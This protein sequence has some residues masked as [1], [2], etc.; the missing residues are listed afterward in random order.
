[1]CAQGAGSVD[2][3]DDGLQGELLTVRCCQLREV[4]RLLSQ[5]R[6][7]RT[8]TA[9]LATVAGST[10][11]QIERLAGLLPRVDRNDAEEQ[12]EQGMP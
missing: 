6:G 10:V 5:R 4:R 3:I 11:A 2:R 9:P 7:D 1:M 8:V 12:Q